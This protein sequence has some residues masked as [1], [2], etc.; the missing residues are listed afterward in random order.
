MRVDG[1]R[2]GVRAQE[3]VSVGGFALELAVR[4]PSRRAGAVVHDVRAPLL[5]PGLG[6]LARRG[7]QRAAGRITDQQFAGLGQKGPEPGSRRRGEGNAGEAATG[8]SVHAL[9]RFSLP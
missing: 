9:P 2:R 4:D 5:A 3:R 6:E 8:E 7:V 1:Q